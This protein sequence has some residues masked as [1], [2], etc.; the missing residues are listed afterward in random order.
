MTNKTIGL[1]FIL[2][3]DKHINKTINMHPDAEVIYIETIQ[4]YNFFEQIKW[5]INLPPT[6]KV[7]ILNITLYNHFAERQDVINYIKNIDDYIKIPFGCDRVIT[8]K[9]GFKKA[10]HYFGKVNYKI[11]RFYSNLNAYKYYENVVKK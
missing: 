10:I 5:E 4:S 11:D 7:L 1:V 8:I 3:S 2:K 6:L 9:D